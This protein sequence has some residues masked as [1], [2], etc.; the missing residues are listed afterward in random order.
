MQHA[1]L[2]EIYLRIYLGA[3][4]FREKEREG[5]VA[6]VPKRRANKAEVYG[7]AIVSVSSVS[8]DDG[9]KQLGRFSHIYW[10]TSPPSALSLSLSRTCP[11]Q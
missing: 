2:D 3:E 6:E 8:G 5:E 9:R 1:G 10:P 11:A 7:A 4:I